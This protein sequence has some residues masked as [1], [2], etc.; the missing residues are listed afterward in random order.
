MFDDELNRIA[1]RF[2]T[3][4]KAFK[5]V[6][7]DHQLVR[8]YLPLKPKNPDD[9]VWSVIRTFSDANDDKG[10]SSVSY[11]EKVTTYLRDIAKENPLLKGI[12]D[13]I[14]FNATTHGER[15]LDDD[16]L[17]NLIEKISEKR[18]GL[19]GQVI[20]QLKIV[21][22]RIWKFLFRHLKNRKK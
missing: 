2:K 18:L 6:E 11:G 20:L 3:R 14:D 5:L 16:R 10:Q 22:L 13:R 17:S 9:D 7:N 12:I 21:S 19:E 1:L 15:D 8:F 4:A